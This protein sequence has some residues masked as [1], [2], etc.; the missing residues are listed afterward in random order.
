MKYLTNIYQKVTSQYS[1]LLI[2]TAA[3]GS[4]GGH[5]LELIVKGQIKEAIGWGLVTLLVGSG[6]YLAHR[7]YQADLNRQLL[8]QEVDTR[9]SPI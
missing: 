2:T 1:V 9:S 4:V 5:T 3:T 6:T 7:N 8:N